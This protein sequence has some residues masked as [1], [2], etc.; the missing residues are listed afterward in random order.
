MTSADTAFL[1]NYSSSA[2]V[3]ATR[4]SC[5]E[6]SGGDD[7]A[8]AKCM[9]DA[10]EAFKPDVIRFKKEGSHWAWTVYK[11]TGSRLDE[12]TTSRVQ[13]SEASPNSVKVTFT[14]G[15]KGM[16]PLLKGKH[17]AV[18]SVPNDYSLEVDDP[19]LGKLIYEAKVGLVA[20]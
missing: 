19:E 5:A 9:S 20:N 4:R 2:V 10:R 8:Q 13:L 7:E 11:R 16:R 6:K 1:I 17:E 12:L 18:F 15:D 14:G 3:E